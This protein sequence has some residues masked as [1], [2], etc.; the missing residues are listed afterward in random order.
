MQGGTV[1]C[2]TKQLHAKIAAQLSHL[3]RVNRRFTRKKDLITN[4]RDAL[5]AEPRENNSKEE[6]AVAAEEALAAAA[7]V[8]GKQNRGVRS[9][10]L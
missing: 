6:M 9:P 2:R 4:R 10:F 3:R 8:N 7:E 5:R 1:T